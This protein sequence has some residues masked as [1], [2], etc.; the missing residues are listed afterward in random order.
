MAKNIQKLKAARL[1][2]QMVQSMNASLLSSRGR[3][4]DKIG[5]SYDG[6]RDL[7]EA[8]G[9]KT[10][11]VWGDY[12]NKY[13]RGG[14]AKR[15]VDAPAKATWRGHPELINPNA[16]ETRDSKDPL[17]SKWNELAKRLRL[18]HYMERVDK[19]AGIGRYGGMF[20]GFN[21]GRT[22]DKEVGP[23]DDVMYL[24]PYHAG[25][26]TVGDINQDVHSPRFG[27]PEY[28]NIAMRREPDTAKGKQYQ[29]NRVHWT[30]VIHVA[31]GLLEDEV[32][33]T[34]RL[35]AVYNHVDDLIKIVGSSGEMFYRGAFP[36]YTFNLDSEAELDDNTADDLDDE[37]EEYMHQMK[38]YLRVQG[39]DVQAIE[40]QVASPQEHAETLLMLIAGTTEIPKRILTGSEEGKLASSQDQAN[41]NSRID[42]RRRDFAEPVILRPFIERLMTYKVLPSIDYDVSW[43]D[44]EALDEG[45]KA[46][47]ATKRAEALFRYTTSPGAMTVVPPHR[48]RRDFLGYSEAESER[49]EKE[50]EGIS[51]DDMLLPYEPEEEQSEVD[52]E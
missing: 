38:R 13:V 28:Y 44:I 29:H 17:T 10:T 50:I 3:L 37:I 25:D 21:D 1:M 51:E 35:E 33:G 8:L 31:E 42:E 14:I 27:M 12:W 52:D 47:I 20:I 16:G 19:M 4:A 7:Y 40:Q 18:W 9:Y 5:E 36:G 48:F 6:D 32:Y 23:C 45:T 26:L 39:V 34:P 22:L 30:R 11:L 24:S 49:I 46:E 15:I 41:W 2:G 43:P